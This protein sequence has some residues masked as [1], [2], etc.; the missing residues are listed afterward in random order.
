MTDAERR[1]EPDR[2]TRDRRRR[3]RRRGTAAAA[4]RSAASGAD[5][6]R[7]GSALL[8]G[9]LVAAWLALQLFASVLLPFVAA[10][11][12]AYVLDPPTT[13]LTRARRAARRSRR[14]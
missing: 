8:V 7:S 4:R 10:A 3:R 11:G 13:R 9:L 14:C 1:R 2:P 12:I 5:A 6:R